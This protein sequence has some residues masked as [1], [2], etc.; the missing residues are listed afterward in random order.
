MCAEIVK[1][2]NASVDEKPHSVVLVGGWG[3]DEPRGIN[4]HRCTHF[5]YGPGN[6]FCGYLMPHTSWE[7]GAYNARDAFGCLDPVSRNEALAALE[8][9]SEIIRATSNSAPGLEPGVV[10]SVVFGPRPVPNHTSLEISAWRQKL[11]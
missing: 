5:A 1:F 8:A 9:D 6:E 10:V 3:S 4:T 11:Q 2:A 7:F